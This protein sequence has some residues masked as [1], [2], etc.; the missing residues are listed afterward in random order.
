MHVSVNVSALQ[1]RS[2]SFVAVVEKILNETGLDGKYLDLEITE[3][4]A[5]RESDNILGVLEELRDL[6]I[7]ISIDDF[8]TEY[9]SLSRL[10]HMPVNRIKIDR[11]FIN[12]LFR[13]EKDQ[14][15]VNGMIHLSQTLGIKVVAE[16]VEHKAQLDFL[17]RNGCDEIQ[18]FYISRP[19]RADEVVELLNRRSGFEG[20]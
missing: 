12:N 3:S 1:L 20:K 13:S 18:G 7:E 5:V 9:S 4:A 15:L 10:N 16:G 14:T 6:G 19:I 8:G 17:R 2:P 11:S